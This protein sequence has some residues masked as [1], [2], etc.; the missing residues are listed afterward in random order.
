MKKKT[1]ILSAAAAAF[2]LSVGCVSAFAAGNN[3]DA[4]DGSGVIC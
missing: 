4:A 2:V 3:S 1:I